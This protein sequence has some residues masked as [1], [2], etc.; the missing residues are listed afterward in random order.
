MNGTSSPKLHVD[1]LDPSSPR[2][3]RL[4]QAEPA[5]V[6]RV[7]RG[8]KMTTD[9]DLFDEVGAALQFPDYFGENWNALEDCLSDLEWMPADCYLIVV[10]EVDTMLTEVPDLL[11]HLLVTFSR[12]A[13]GWAQTANRPLPDP[14]PFHVVLRPHRATGE[15][16]ELLV[17]ARL[18]FDRQAWPADSGA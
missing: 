8:S 10:T 5:Q 13:Q 11:E 2:A 7:L 16:L 17:R 12:V 9:A 14:R 4:V 1:S 18:D 6:V 15:L 3:R